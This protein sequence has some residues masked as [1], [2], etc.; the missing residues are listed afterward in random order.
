MERHFHERLER[1]NQK[2]LE[3]AALTEEAIFRATEALKNV[4]TGL[5][6]KVIEKDSVIDMMEIEIESM[7]IDLLALQQ[8]MAKDLRFVTTGMKVN[9]ELERIADLATNIAK[10][11]I[12]IADKPALALIEDIRKLYDI[13]LAMVKNAV[14]AFVNRDYELA[15]K[16]ILSDAEADALRTKIQDDLVNNYMLKDKNLISRAVSFFLVTRHYERMCDHAT[17]IA[18][19]VIFMI[20][21]KVVKHHPEI[22]A[23]GQEDAS[24]T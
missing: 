10:C 9:T 17:N 6:E 1:L 3:M 7:V 16:V 4:D 12:F 22:L 14:N 23:E 24:Q 21:A 18:E 11:V 19:D 5:A 8:P 20:D 13:A 2:L 15:K